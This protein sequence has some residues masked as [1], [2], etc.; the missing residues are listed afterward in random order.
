MDIKM[1]REKNQFGKK[2]C[3]V[4]KVS[5]GVQK[6]PRMQDFAPFTPKPFGRDVFKS[7]F[8]IREHNQVCL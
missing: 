6:N 5:R 3:G 7:A 8:F 1:S 2:K 4:L